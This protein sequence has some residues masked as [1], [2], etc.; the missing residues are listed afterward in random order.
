M[1]RKRLSALSIP[2][3][4]P[5]DWHDTIVPGLILR[6]GANRSTW[7][8]R[9]SA[10]GR[11]L[12]LTLGYHP[13]MG[14]ASAR[15][16]CRKAS[17][18]IDAGAM[19]TA[20]MPHPRSADALTL[21]SLLDRYEA[22]R[23]RE[24]RRIKTLPE[25]MRLLRRGL[26]PY[27][28]L[29]AREFAKSDLRAARDALVEAGAVFAGNR[30]IAYLSPALAWAARED[31]ISANFAGA[32]RKA[33]E[34]K[35]SRVLTKKEIAAIWKA[36]DKLGASE[37]AQNFG[38]M[39][40]FLLM[41]AQRRGEVASLRHGDILNDT[42]RQV[43]NKSSRPH[44]IPLPSLAIGLVGQGTAQQLVFPGRSGGKISGFSKLKAE[45][46]RASGVSGWRLHDLRRTAATH[47][48][49]LGIRHEIISAILNHS[50]PGVGAVYLRSELEAQKAE[51]LQIW[52]AAL[53]K[54]VRPRTL[55]AS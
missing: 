10:G 48:Q 17:E 20:P 47:L 26:G 44:S 27:L 15:E 29:P 23:T 8:Y 42:W 34:Q 3:L 9:Y 51:A 49:E 54:I 46:D 28:S 32:V 52:S 30:L 38:R 1:A 7:T 21:G 33:P 37:A 13:A 6:V 50:L 2:K 43:D 14:L 19:P 5:G 12:R 24:G 53:A 16:A 36:C 11:K 55:I 45:L 39:V 35:R 22:L 18:R 4:S 40:R 41:T 31:L 25:Q